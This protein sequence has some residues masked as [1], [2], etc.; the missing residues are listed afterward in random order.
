MP[1]LSLNLLYYAPVGLH[2]GMG[3][4]GRFIN[5]V[6]IL[7]RLEVTTQ[8]ISYRPDARFKITHERESDILRKTTIHVPESLP[9]FLKA[10]SIPLMLMYG[11]RYANRSDIVFAHGPT[12]VSGF[13]AMIL[14]KMFRKPLV[15][16]HMDINDAP[17]FI[18]NF[19]LKNSTFILAISHYLENEA[20]EKGCRNVV[21]IPNS[22][23]TD[24]FIRD[25]SVGRRIR[26]ELGIG[27]NEI[28]VGYTGSFWNVHGVSILLKT[29]SRLVKRHANIR[30]M[31]VGGEISAAS[32]NVPLLIEKLALEEKVSVIP[33][34]PYE[35][36]PGYLSACDIA[37][38]PII[39]CEET[40]AAMPIKIY[41]YMSMGL[42]VVASAVG[43]ISNLI[44]N[45][46][47][48]FLVMPADEID[49]EKTLEYVA[50]NLESAKEVGK[51][52]RKEVVS[53]YS[54]R[55]AMEKVGEIFERALARSV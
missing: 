20:K 33:P 39:D 16:D 49:L 43:G 18:Y 44:K 11:L 15:V 45:G 54:Q 25:V 2:Q 8:L 9:K 21:Y 42:P 4:G 35:S 24:Y 55:A 6:D 23:D 34:Q 10:F 41:E 52:A 5:M 28:V 27:D 1:K 51:R 17:S 53:N 13:P 19:V 38:A 22:V 31:V 12:V 3:G 37:C 48:G 46:V 29:F 26:K 50:Q 14:A 7:E 47:N 40:R 30:L 32:D 36:V